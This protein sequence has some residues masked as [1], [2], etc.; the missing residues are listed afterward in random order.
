MLDDNVV[1]QPRGRGLTYLPIISYPLIGTLATAP[2]TITQGTSHIFTANTSGGTAPYTYTLYVDGIADSN[3]TSQPMTNDYIN[4]TA[5]VTFSRT[6]N[7]SVGSHTYAIKTTDSCPT[8]AATSPADSAVIMITS[9]AIPTTRGNTL[10]Y[11]TALGFAA[12]IV[13]SSR[14]KK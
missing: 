11:L 6:F 7:E 1:P 2:S 8:G 9:A 13:I 4:N 3:F 14:K 10:M 12:A 5:T